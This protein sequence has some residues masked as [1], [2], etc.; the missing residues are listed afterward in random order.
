MKEKVQILQRILHEKKKYL[1][2][3]G[4]ANSLYSFLTF[5]NCEFKC[6]NFENFSHNT[7]F[8]Q[9][10]LFYLNSNNICN[11]ILY[12]KK[13]KKNSNNTNVYSISNLKIFI[14]L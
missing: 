1:I 5:S 12:Q 6:K 9:T 13:K 10:L 2:C 7:N 11:I 14:N 8:F 3:G 4:S